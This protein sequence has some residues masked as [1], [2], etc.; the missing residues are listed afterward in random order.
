MQAAYWL[1]RSNE[2]IS[3]VERMQAAYWL[4][5]SNESMSLVIQMQAVR[6]LNWCK[7]LIDRQ[8]KAF[9]WFYRCKLFIHWPEKCKLF[10]DWRDACSYWLEGCKLFI[11]CTEL[12]MQFICSL[13]GEMQAVHFLYRST[14]VIVCSL[15]GEMQAVHCLYRSI[16]T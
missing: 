16:Q 14:D 12:Q 8:M 15:V 3:L 10:I 7:L 1:E 13:A 6:L 11:G 2:S 9:H 5:R 4:E